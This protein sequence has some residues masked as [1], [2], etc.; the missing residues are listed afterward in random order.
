MKPNKMWLFVYCHN[1]Q[2]KWYHCQSTKEVASNRLPLVKDDVDRYA[3]WQLAF[4]MAFERKDPL[5]LLKE[6][7]AKISSVT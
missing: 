7:N 3:K 4:V 1:C 5:R 6:R 2:I